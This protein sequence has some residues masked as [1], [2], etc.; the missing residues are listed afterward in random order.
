M[1]TL[2][3]ATLFNS[4]FH[5]A[6]KIADKSGKLVKYVILNVKPMRITDW[7]IFKLPGSTGRFSSWLEEMDGF[8]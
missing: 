5:V 4:L 1:F 2:Q 3:M 7:L 8:V 6:K